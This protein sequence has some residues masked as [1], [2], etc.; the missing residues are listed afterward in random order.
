MSR[1][2]KP[3]FWLC[4][5]ALLALSL[6]PVSPELPTTG[7]DKSNHFVG[8][9]T[10]A[11]L[12]LPA[13]PRYRLAVLAGLVLYGGLIE[14]LQSFTTYRQAE[15]LDLLADAIGVAGGF[16]LYLPIQRLLTKSR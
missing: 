6:A 10:L 16:A 8:F 1:Y 13:Y 2:W 7:W 4:A 12:G 14:V 15:W 11:L 3:A 5:I 9:A